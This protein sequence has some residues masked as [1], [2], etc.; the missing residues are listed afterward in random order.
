MKTFGEGIKNKL[1]VIILSY[2]IDEDIYEMNCRALKSL[3]ESEK[4][5]DNLQ[6][7]VIES[8]KDS[9]YTYPWPNVE[10][11]IPNE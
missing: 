7:L 6:V 9:N 11:L 2:A 3:V 10:V 8:K 1:S 5:S 4:W